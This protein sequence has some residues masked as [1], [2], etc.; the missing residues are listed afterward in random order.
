MEKQ[1]KAKFIPTSIV[2][3]LTYFIHGIGA[4]IL[5]QQ[6]IKEVLVGQWGYSD[7]AANISVV[8]T[9]SAAL[10]LGRLIALPF[11]GPLSDKLGRKIAVLIGT[12]AYA[13]FFLGLAMSPS[14]SVAYA[15]AIMGGIANS[16]L[17]CGVIPA[18][19]EIMSPN[20]GLATMGTKLFIAGG[21]KVLPMLVGYIIATA[22]MEA[23]HTRTVLMALAVVIVGVGI[24]S[25]ILPMPAEE[26]KTAERKRLLLTISRAQS[27]RL[28]VLR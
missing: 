17:D 11:A 8:T 14:M 26:K 27:G 10:G 19:V 3:Y 25:M 7:I 5:G 16:F 18:E 28:R 21:Q 23:G 13:I 2:L 15:A 1:S 4:A 6:A 12:V 22:G 24:V 9:V 20:T